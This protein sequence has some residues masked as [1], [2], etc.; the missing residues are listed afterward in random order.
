[1]TDGSVSNSDQIIQLVEKNSQHVQTFTLGIGSAVSHYLVNGVARAGNGESEFILPGEKIQ[2]KLLRQFQR[3]VSNAGGI[4]QNLLVRWKPIYLSSIS[5]QNPSKIS[6]VYPGD[7]IV[8]TARIDGID[9][10]MVLYSKCL[11]LRDFFSLVQQNGQDDE[12]PV[13]LEK[14]PIFFTKDPQSQA[15]RKL[16]A[17]RK[18]REM[19]ET[20]CD[21]EEPGACEA[22]A[23]QI[24]V[25]EGLLSRFTSFIAVDPELGE[26]EMSKAFKSIHI[27][28]QQPTTKSGII[29]SSAGLGN[30]VHNPSP[31]FHDPPSHLP[32][33]HQGLRSNKFFSIFS[34]SSASSYSPSSF[35][36]LTF[37]ILSAFIFI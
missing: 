7:R 27:P 37:I 23:T 20:L 33:Q 16:A 3:T 12:Q 31:P 15:I 32:V 26:R 36:L 18:I 30:G 13:S 5:Y 21:R 2:A 22:M 6:M 11:V 9:P 29:S 24:A 1:M 17:R 14:V 25:Q 8:A 28:L 19:E 35:I 4:L 34:I 10:S